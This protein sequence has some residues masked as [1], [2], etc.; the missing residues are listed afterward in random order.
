MGQIRFIAPSFTP[1]AKQAQEALYPTIERG[2]RGEGMFGGL[3]YNTRIG[4]LEALEREYANIRSDFHGQVSRFVPRS[5]VKVRSYLDKALTAQYARGRESIGREF[6][7]NKYNDLQYAQQL[8]FGALGAEKGVATT[9]AGMATE[10]G[11]RG[12]Q[13][14][15]FS[16]TLA[17]G[18]GGA[19]GITLGGEAKF[20]NLFSSNRTY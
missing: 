13:M 14:P 16:S 15:D 4:M 6:D 1:E 9:M 12:L 10:S 20:A 7:F 17:G 5:D 2:L 19:A 11:L 3:D 8:G 18:F